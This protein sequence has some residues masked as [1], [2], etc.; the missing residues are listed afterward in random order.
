MVSEDSAH[1]GKEWMV[2]QRSSLWEQEGVGGVGEGGEEKGRER[3]ENACPTGFLLFPFLFH[4]G[5]QLWDDGMAQPI[6]HI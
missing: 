5:L 4:L 1:C 2:E 3:I 6:Y